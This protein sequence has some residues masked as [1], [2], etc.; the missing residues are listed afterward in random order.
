MGKNVGWITLFGLALCGALQASYFT[1]DVNA[2]SAILIC[3]DSGK[4]LFAKNAT[5]KHFPAS[6]TKIAT[7]LYT[8]KQF[9]HLLNKRVQCP[10]EALR[11]LTEAEKSKGNFS[12]YP[13]YVLETDMSHMGLKVGEEMSFYDLLLGTLVVS[14]DDASNVIAHTAGNGSIDSFMQGLNSFMRQLGLKNTTFHNPHGLHHPEHLSTAYDLALLCREAMKDPMFADIVKMARFERPKTNKQHP[15]TLHQTNKLLVKSSPHYYPHATGGK[16]GYHRRARH[17]LVSTAEKNGRRLIAVVLHT[18]KRA[19]MFHDSKKL[20]E[21]AFKEQ[22]VTKELL[23]KGAQTFQCEIIGGKSPLSTY[24]QDSLTHSFYPSVAPEFRCQLVWNELKAPVNKGQA[25]GSLHLLADGIVIKQVT[26]YAAQ[27]VEP[28]WTYV[29]KEK[30]QKLI[31]SRY[32][33]ASLGFLAI[34][35]LFLFFATS[36]PAKQRKM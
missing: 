26:L 16:T 8:I 1:C 9:K 31:A 6:I 35:L 27:A 19:D 34:A 17:N 33:W 7:G 22:K 3:A 14:A 4:V 13:S 18:D 36:T 32:L 30:C 2:E 29:V 23:A 5:D 28:S 24:T 20:F 25:V 21:M 12:K 11:C 10:P 15:V